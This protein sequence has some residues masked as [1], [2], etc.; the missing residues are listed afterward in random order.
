MLVSQ[1]I[2]DLTFDGGSISMKKLIAVL[3]AIILIFSMVSCGKPY[4]VKDLSQIDSI[5]IR[6]YSMTSQ[7]YTDYAI[8]E[9]EKVQEICNLFSSLN[10]KQY[11]TFGSEPMKTIYTI[12]F[13]NSSGTAIEHISVI[14]DLQNTIQV[15]SSNGL[16]Q[17]TSD[18]N[19]CQYIEDAIASSGESIE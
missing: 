12:S 15:S 18:I 14:F 2:D 16:Y 8:T 5:N 11:H 19:I 17:I 1:L 4:E 13:L 7:G 6:V 3:C 9:D 10:A